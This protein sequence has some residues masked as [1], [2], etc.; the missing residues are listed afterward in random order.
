MNRVALSGLVVV[1][2]LSHTTSSRAGAQWMDGH[3]VSLLD[4]PDG[5]GFANGAL[6]AVRASA[7]DVQYIGCGIDGAPNEYTY[8]AHWRP[9]GYVAYY[10][11]GALYGIYEGSSWQ[12][13]VIRQA[14]FCAARNR[15]GVTRMCRSAN[16]SLIAIA[17]SVNRNS[18]VAFTWNA[19][20]E[21]T[22]VNVEQA[23]SYGPRPGSDVAW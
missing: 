14:M 20:G 21:C 15:Q 8:M 6:V 4:H 16:R 7:D 2:L 9:A 23:S 3:E 1:A 10:G 11:G 22:S 5:T 13:T 12:E 19:D 17:A 18:R